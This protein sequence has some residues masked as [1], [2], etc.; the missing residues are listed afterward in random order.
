M[1]VKE[2]IEQLKKYNNLDD[3]IVCAYWTYDDV[4][5][6]MM[7]LIKAIGMNLYQ[8]LMTMISNRLVMIF[9]M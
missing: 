5:I 3:E 6:V 2:L 4:T 8:G 7:I 9:T 1:K